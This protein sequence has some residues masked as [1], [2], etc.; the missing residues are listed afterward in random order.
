MLVSRA[1]AAP[2]SLVLWGWEVLYAVGGVG[3]DDE[4]YYKEVEEAGLFE[5]APLDGEACEA[6]VVGMH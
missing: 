2:V 4:A 1:L 3:A 5:E 6:S